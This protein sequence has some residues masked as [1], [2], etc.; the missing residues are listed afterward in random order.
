MEVAVAR[1][2]EDATRLTNGHFTRTA[3][4]LRESLYP[5]PVRTEMKNEI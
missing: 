4:L 2:A 1:R 3:L 5:H